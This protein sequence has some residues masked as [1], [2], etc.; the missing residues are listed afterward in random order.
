MERNLFI[1][2]LILLFVGIITMPYSNVPRQDLVPEVV[3]E[4]TPENQKVSANFSSG[5]LFDM[6]ISPRAS[7]AEP[8][9]EKPGGD[10]PFP[11]R[12]V[13][14]NISDPTG[15]TKTFE[16]AFGLLDGGF[17]LYR[18]NEFSANLSIVSS[19]DPEDFMLRADTSGPYT[20]SIWLV[21]PRP[22]DPFA[23][24]Q[25]RK[26]NVEV[27]RVYWYLLPLG[28]ILSVF[29]VVVLALAKLEPWKGKRKKLAKKRTL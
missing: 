16:F 6:F 27:E 13:W 15:N 28:T 11:S 25:I 2:G 20:A 26:L 5:E 29:G 3:A 7:W 4:A 1:L 8:P 22:K 19:L 14:V 24:F 12:F 21:A 18:V 23:S 9:L 10:V 17:A